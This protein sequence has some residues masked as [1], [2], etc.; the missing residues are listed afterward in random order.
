M[1]WT[2][3]EKELVDE[4]FTRVYDAIESNA[5]LN[6]EHFKNQEENT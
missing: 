1:A 2:K 4:R 3:A 5:K 6:I